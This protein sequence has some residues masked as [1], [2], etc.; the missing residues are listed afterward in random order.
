MSRGSR[1]T[2]LDPVELGDR[3]VV[4]LD[5][6]QPERAVLARPCRAG[7]SAIEASTSER[8][9]LYPGTAMS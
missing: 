8:F 4:E 3:G 5:L 7:T 2:G 1:A 6:P 9:A